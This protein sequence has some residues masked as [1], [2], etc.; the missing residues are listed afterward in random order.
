LFSAIAR[1]AFSSDVDASL[2]RGFVHPVAAMPSAI[3]TVNI[4]SESFRY[5]L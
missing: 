1:V 5:L 2:V 3:A 4:F